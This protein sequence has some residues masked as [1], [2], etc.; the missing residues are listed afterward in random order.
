[1]KWKREMVIIMRRCC[2]SVVLSRHYD[3]IASSV[4]NQIP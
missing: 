2:S 1:M 4:S 3:E